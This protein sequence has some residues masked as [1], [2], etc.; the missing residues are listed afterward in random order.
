[1]MNRIRLQVDTSWHTPSPSML[2]EDA[3]N[4]AEALRSPTLL[5]MDALEE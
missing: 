5:N 4:A 2:E 3:G 1:M